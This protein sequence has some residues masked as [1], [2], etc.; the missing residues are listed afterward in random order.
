MNAVFAVLSGLL[1]GVGLMVGGMTDPAKVKGFLDIFGAWDPSLAVVM[2]GAIA[3]G[4]LAFAR[5]RRRTLSWTGA[6]IEI[7]TNSVVDARLL[8]GGVLFGAGWGVAGFCPGPAIVAASTGSAEALAFV[9]AML[10]GMTLH[11]RLRAKT[12]K[13]C[14]PQPAPPAAST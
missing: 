10:F 9:A 7:P 2:G 14:G 3:V 6:H 4:A 12:R 8:L 13:G 1:F 5:A 11:D